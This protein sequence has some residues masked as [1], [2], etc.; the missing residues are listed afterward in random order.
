MPARSW[1]ARVAVASPKPA[2]AAVCSAVA[3]L[4]LGQGGEFRQRFLGRLASQ[5]RIGFL[6]MIEGFPGAV[7]IEPGRLFTEPRQLF[8]EFIR[9]V[10]SRIFSSS[11]AWTSALSSSTNCPTS[12]RPPSAA[13]VNRS[14]SSSA[15][16]TN[17]AERPNEP[18]AP[19][20]RHFRR[21]GFGPGIG[22]SRRTCRR[23]PRS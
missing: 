15:T 12:S 23:L 7:R 2:S 17:K 21:G 5:I 18:I 19:A 14:G 8:L 16:A 6:D 11:R 20:L 1:A 22:I 9:L 3:S 13:M 4:G 10:S